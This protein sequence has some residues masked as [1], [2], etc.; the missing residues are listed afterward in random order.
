MP[1]VII[2]LYHNR[3]NNVYQISSGII[4]PGCGSIILHKIISYQ[5]N[6]N[7]NYNNNNETLCNLGH[8]KKRQSTYLLGQPSTLSFIHI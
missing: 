3:Y 8:S 6:N 1:D 4:I 7:N 2:S 5:M